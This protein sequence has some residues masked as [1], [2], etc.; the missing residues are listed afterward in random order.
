MIF[1]IE[2]MVNDNSGGMTRL[3]DLARGDRMNGETKT[4]C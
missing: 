1:S 4:F 3:E 2:G